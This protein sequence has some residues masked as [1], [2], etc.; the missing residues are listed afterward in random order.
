[1]LF[2]VV[3]PCYCSS[4]TLDPVIDEIERVFLGMNV[5]DYEIILVNDCSPDSGATLRKIRELGAQNHH[6][7]GL[8]LAKNVGQ[9][10]AIMAGLR[11]ATGDF[12]VLG[13]D[14]GQTPF[15][16]LCEMYEKLLTQDY[17]VV[18]GRYISRGKRSAFRQFGSYLA[19]AANN[20]VLDQP[21]GVI[22]SV[23]FVARKFVIE[24]MTRYD[25]PYP[26]IG[27]LLC[28]ATNNIGNVELEQ[29][30][31]LSG[32]SGY[33]FKKLLDL[34]LNGFTAFSVKPLR[35]SSL[36]GF[37]AAILGFLLGVITVIRKLVNPMIAA[38]YTSTIAI[39]LL[40]GGML[41]LVL[42][43]I[44]EYIGRIYISIN[45]FPQY[46]IRDRINFTEDE[47][48]QE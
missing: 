16:A 30:Q 8:S 3:I 17:D 39:I 37:I 13:D 36:L 24:E 46:V 28:R 42:G 18:C 31:R 44:G 29:R 12:V 27:G 22:V 32:N 43:M 2:S 20:W 10:A 9:A 7:K 14:D 34:W 11:H 21:R 47:S 33:S 38:G 19:K 5:S 15:T 4:K 45:N 41:M 1:M 6:I 40:I 48:P 25:N 23:F 26:F 35:V